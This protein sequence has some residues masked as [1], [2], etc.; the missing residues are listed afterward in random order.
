MVSFLMETFLEHDLNISQRLFRVWYVKSLLK[1]WRE[2]LVKRGYKLN[3]H[4]LDYKTYSDINIVCDSFVSLL[5]YCWLNDLW[6]CPH[7]FTSDHCEQ[8]LFFCRIGRFS[9]RRTN[10]SGS[11]VAHGLA[12]RNRSIEV[13]SKSTILEPKPIAH[14]RSRRWTYPV[15][16]R[17][18]AKKLALLEM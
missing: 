10:M 18:K 8:V 14:A 3:D 12:K 1:L 16:L 11:D 9:G 4:F 6:F 2:W 17:L 5:L 13:E 7:F 15:I